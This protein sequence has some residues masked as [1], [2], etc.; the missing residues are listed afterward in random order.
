L[1]D[2]EYTIGPKFLVTMPDVLEDPGSAF[3]LP[4][5]RGVATATGLQYVVLFCLIGSL[6]SLLSAKAIELHD[7]WKRKTNFDRDLLAVGAANTLAS[8]VGALP[9]ISE[10]VRSKANIDNGA[11]TRGANLFHGLFLLGFVLLFPDL[12][13]CIP[14][15]A[16]GAM[17]VYTGFR[18]ANPAEFVRAYKIGSEQFVVF[19]GT[20]I[21]T[22]AADLLIGI[23]VGIALKIA[24]HL[25]HGCPLGGLFRADVEVVPEGDR[26]AVVI[27]K[28][29]AVFTNWLGLRAKILAAAEGRD[30][31]VIDLSRT[32]FVDHSVM[33]KLHQLQEEFAHAGKRLSLLG[34]EGHI[35]LSPHPLAARKNHGREPV[36]TVA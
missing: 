23:G 12:I 4:D 21:A 3:A 18:L 35:P 14:L 10:I 24:F 16:L 5:F 31:V 30:E 32:R 15:A 9:M 1:E 25:R 33:E 36:G 19:V 27:V 22:L 17:L 11:R 20:I 28:R 7:P 6:E 8:A 29:A 34:L 26:L 2:A 13:H